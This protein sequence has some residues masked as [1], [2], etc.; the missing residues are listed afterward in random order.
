M[1]AHV[2]EI[3]GNYSLSDGTFRIVAKAVDP[4]TGRARFKERYTR[5]W[6]QR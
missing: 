1:L 3:P 6:I 2:P 5:V 4:K